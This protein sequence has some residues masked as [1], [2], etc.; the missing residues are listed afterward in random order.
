MYDPRTGNTIAMTGQPN[1]MMMPSFS[2]DGK[3]VV[4]NDYESGN[5]HSL[6]V[7]DFAPGANGSPD[8]FSNKKTLYQD[9]HLYLGWPFFTPDSKSVIFVAGDAPTYASS[10]TSPTNTPAQGQLAIA[11]VDG[12][13]QPHYLDAANGR[14]TDGNVYL[15]YGARDQNLSFYPTVSPV[16]AGGYFWVY[17]TSRRNYG[18][19]N[20]DPDN[21][22]ASKQLWVAAIDFTSAETQSNSDRSHPAF[23]LPGQELKSGNI[24][25][26]SALDPCKSDGQSCSSGVDCCNGACNSGSCGSVKGCS[27]TDEKCS[28]NVDCCT[29]QALTCLGGFCAASAQ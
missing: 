20:V 28:T 24:R 7:M 10:S 27:K 6:A 17:F 23:F 15:P 8:T 14:L 19:L 12:S 29:G 18:N 22:P 4:F 16:A 26:F 9:A 5:G 25:A 21:G 13:A 2:P 3:Q 1:Y 11:D